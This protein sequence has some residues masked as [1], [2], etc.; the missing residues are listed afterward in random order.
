MHDT[1]HIALL[2]TSARTVLREFYFLHPYEYPTVDRYNLQG[3]CGTASLLLCELYRR[4]G[5]TKQVSVQQ[6][7]NHIDPR[8]CHCWVRLN[9]NLFIDITATQFG[10]PR[11]YM[12]KN[13][14]YTI[15]DDVYC[16]TPDGI[17]VFNTM[18]VPDVNVENVYDEMISM[19]NWPEHE[20]IHPN[21]LS[22]L[23]DDVE[24]EYRYLLD[25]TD[26]LAVA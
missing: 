7:Y 19:L 23:A 13:N 10:G 15:P 18:P 12:S 14:P 26:G 1:G 3:A 20:L 17:A 8:G 2:A 22:M 9:N 11:L 21:K 16:W 4:Y 24:D 6:I 5:F 25:N